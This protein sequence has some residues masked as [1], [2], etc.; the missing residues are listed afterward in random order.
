[1]ENQD[2]LHLDTVVTRADAL[3]HR[4]RQTILADSLEPP[5]LTEVIPVEATL[6]APALDPDMPLFTGIDTSPA[7][8]M[9]RGTGVPSLPAAAVPDILLEELSCQLKKRL[10]GTIPALVESALDAALE[11]I[12]TEIRQGLAARV[13]TAI[14]DILAE[15]ASSTA[16]PTPGGEATMNLA[17]VRQKR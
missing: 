16:E 9:E 11:G 14:D 8:R 6:P 15:R 13:E 4:R 2:K 12:I 3:M 1:M 7:T 5:I 17:V 10:A